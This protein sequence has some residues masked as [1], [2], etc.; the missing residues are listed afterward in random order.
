MFAD[1]LVVTL[2]HLRHDL[3]HTVLGLLFRVGHSTI[4]RAVGQDR[5]LLTERGYAALNRPRLRLRTVE[6]G[7]AYTQ[8]S[9]SLDTE[10]RGP[11][12]SRQLHL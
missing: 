12:N 5:A 8:A 7:F 4:T 11:R 1:R 2:I 6:V 9:A 3:P 10:V